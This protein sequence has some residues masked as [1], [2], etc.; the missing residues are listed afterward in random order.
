MYGPSTT[1]GLARYYIISNEGRGAQMKLSMERRV[2][3]PKKTNE[4]S[5]RAE[6]SDGI[7]LQKQNYYLASGESQGR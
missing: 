2:L 5:S 7:N 3:L 1:L 4:L 6:S